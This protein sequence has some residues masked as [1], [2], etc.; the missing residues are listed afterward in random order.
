MN[1]KA[2]KRVEIAKD[3]LKTLRYL[4]VSTGS[5]VYG[6]IRNLKGDSAQKNLPK[7][8]K[9]CHVCA[10]GACFLSF[11]KIEKRV[12]IKD[13]THSCYPNEVEVDFSFIESKL[14]KYFGQDQLFKIEAACEQ[15]SAIHGERWYLH[16]AARFRSR[17]GLLDVS[18][19]DLLKAIMQN[20][21]KNKGTFI[22]PTETTYVA[23]QS[24]TS[25]SY[26]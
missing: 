9:K 15:S 24:T 26:C 10:L 20:I 18:E 23:Y 4:S 8:R 13:I 19:K 6:E 1:A 5:Y 12:K 7:I 2:L 17:S 16:D 3:V 14:K 22:P 25:D 11:V 21:V